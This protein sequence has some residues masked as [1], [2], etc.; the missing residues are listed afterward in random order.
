MQQILKST[1]RDVSL[2]ANIL[3]AN[4][5]VDLIFTWLFLS[6]SGLQF[7]HFCGPFICGPLVRQN[8]LLLAE[9]LHLSDLFQPNPN[10][11]HQITLLRSQAFNSEK[12]EPGVHHLDI[13]Q[14]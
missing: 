13:S 6:K 5:R 4:P 14:Q 9:N 12:C 8:H 11:K 1:R 7:K 10:Q 3:G 2:V